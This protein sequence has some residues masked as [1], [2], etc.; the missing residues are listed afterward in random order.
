LKKAVELDE[1]QHDL[2]SFFQDIESRVRRITI[3]GEES[4]TL[5]ELETMDTIREEI[6]NK[7]ADYQRTMEFAQAI[8]SRAH[9]RAETSMG[10]LLRSLTSSWDLL[11]Q[12]VAEKEDKLKTVYLIWIF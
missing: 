3:P 9:P 2:L 8:S 1:Q 12:I 11:G 7:K 6:L 10:H 5:Q 4:Q